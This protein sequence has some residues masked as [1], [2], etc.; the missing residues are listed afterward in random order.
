MAFFFFFHKLL[1]AY[2]LFQLRL[3]PAIAE[4]WQYE[5]CPPAENN[6]LK[7]NSDNLNTLLA[8]IGPKA[9]SNNGYFND[10][11]G[12]EP[13]QV[14]GLIMCYADTNRTSCN[15]NCLSAASA[16]QITRRCPDSPDAAFW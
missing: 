7:G 8:S 11:V 9:Q 2:L 4:F 16:I 13:K 1:A 10:T 14:Y 5:F 3:F 6:T 12:T 15:N